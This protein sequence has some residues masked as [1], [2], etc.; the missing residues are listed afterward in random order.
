MLGN[1]LLTSRGSPPSAN[2]VLRCCGVIKNGSLYTFFVNPKWRTVI[3]WVFIMRFSAEAYLRTS[4]PQG[5][6]MV[7][8][9]KHCESFVPIG[10]RAHE[11]FTDNRF[12]LLFIYI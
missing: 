2:K 9:P 12:Q 6:S 7:G 5:H 4:L 8:V 11:E 3:F 1:I 10:L